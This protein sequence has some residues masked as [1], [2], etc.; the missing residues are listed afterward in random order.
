MDF[1]PMGEEVY[2]RTYSRT[3]PDGTKETWPET[4]KRVAEANVALAGVFGSGDLEPLREAIEDFRIIPAGRHLWAAGAESGLGLFNCHRAGWGKNL[5]DHFAFLFD[6]LMLGGGV[7]ANYSS[8]YLRALPPITL[9]PRVAFTM[10]EWH[11]D[12]EALRSTSVA[13]IEEDKLDSIPF[14]VD[15]SRQGW[16]SALSYYLDTAT[17][18]RLVP[19]LCFD[20]SGVRPSGAP[21]RGF[22]GTASGPVPLALALDAV[23]A[24]L[25]EAEETASGHLNPLQAMEID[26]AIAS[27]VVAGNVRRSARM[28]I[29][30]WQDPYIRDFIACKADPS[31]HWTTNISVEV[32]SAFWQKVSEDDAGAMSLLRLLSAA[33]LSNGEPGIYNS[34]LASVGEAN[35]VRSTNPCG[36]IALEEWE[37]CCLGHVNLAHPA[38]ADEEELKR[39]FALMARFLVRATEAPSSSPEQE[40][41]KR[42]N[43][44]IGVGVFGFQEWLAAKGIRYSECFTVPNVRQSLLHW[45]RTIKTAAE[46]EANRLC[47]PVPVKTTTVAPTGTIA[48]LPGTTEGIH[49]VYAKHFIRRV[50]YAEDSPELERLRAEGYPVEPCQYSA[51]SQVVSFFVE[52]SALSCIGSRHIESVDE[53]SLRDMLEVQA[54]FQAF[55]ADNAVSFTA[56]VSPDAYTVE[57]L[58]DVL[59]SVGPRL[60]GT[61]IFPDLSRPQSPMERITE[62]QYQAAKLHE[63]GQ[64]IDEECTT[65]ACPVR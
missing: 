6:Q 7:G 51:R 4:A 13:F 3:K 49:P 18:S 41:V 64:S 39:S 19:T 58:V 25:L 53:I 30:H 62:A 12:Y 8:E 57:K 40:K 44:R 46:E 26:H 35:D 28:S 34:S 65:G 45:K 63:Q 52:D 2:R 55:Y 15:D 10:G 29:L 17:S 47:V 43:R 37:Q 32:D 27:C 54:M 36:E 21:I 23:A 56:N 50:R 1:G 9:A 5:S 60:K 11:P 61:T 24:I 48:K 59:M 22:G 38:H 31:K 14:Y 42:R 16:V 33:M 20:L